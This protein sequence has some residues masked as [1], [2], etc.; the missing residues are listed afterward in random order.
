LTR[1]RLLV[2]VLLVALVVAVGG[3]LTLG[4]VGLATS[5]TRT[6]STVAVAASNGTTIDL[7]GPMYVSVLGG[8]GADAALAAELVASLREAG[9]DAS[10]APE[11][12]AVHDRPVLVVATVEYDVEWSVVRGD[13]TARWGV[14]YVQSGDL[15]QFGESSYGAGDYDES[16]LYGRLVD[17]AEGRPVHTVV[18]DTTSYVLTGQFAVTDRTRGV[19]SLARYDRTLRTALVEATVEALVRA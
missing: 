1:T 18:D 6:D 16:R 9:V 15:T 17:L 19:V 3:A 12:R 14:L 5:E 13:G 4:D 8:T 10:L 2:S 11:D 7:S